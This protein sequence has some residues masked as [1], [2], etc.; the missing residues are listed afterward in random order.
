MYTQVLTEV[1]TYVLTKY[2]H[3]L[4]CINVVEQTMSRRVGVGPLT[5][6][7]AGRAWKNWQ[8]QGVA[9]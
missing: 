3:V 7:S 9:F 1:S 5:G 8:M 2:L 4:T 6:K